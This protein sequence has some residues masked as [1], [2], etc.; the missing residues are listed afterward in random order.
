MIAA[1]H[2]EPLLAIVHHVAARLDAG[3]DVVEIEVPDPDLS[4]GRFAGET[5]RDITGVEVVHRPLRV[6]V[7]LAQRMQLRLHTPRIVAPGRV[8]LRFARLAD[9]AAWGEGD[10]T[11][12]YGAASAYQRIHRAEDPGFVLDLKDALERARLPPCP[13]VLDLGCNTGDVIALVRELVADRAPTCVGIDHSASAIAAARGR[14]S[15]DEVQLVQ[16]DLA[17]LP[18]LDL[19]RF[20]LV[21]AIATLQSPGVDDR[22]V[23]RHVVQNLLPPHGTLVIA[24]PNCRYQGGEL[25][26]GA[27]T[28][29][30][31]QPE[32]G[33]LVRNAE[34]YRRYLAQHRRRVFITGTHYLFV[35]GVGM[36]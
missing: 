19:A 33:L 28:K 11:E 15:A 34:F 10:P 12:R 4:P 13:R 27:R 18:V 21:L 5:L 1:F 17:A 36:G 14:F 23:V 7:D 6:W 30:F 3:E 16:A 20:D 35:T 22:A 24:I 9:E 31:R 2:A 8:R 29:N 25:L 32:L 26:H